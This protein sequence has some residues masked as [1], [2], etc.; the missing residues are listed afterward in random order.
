MKTNKKQSPTK[1]SQT[2]HNGFF[3]PCW[4]IARRSNKKPTKAK[5]LKKGGILNGQERVS[6]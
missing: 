5:R 1:A 6:S 2:A 4:L 3:S